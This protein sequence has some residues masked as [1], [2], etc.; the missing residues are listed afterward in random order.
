LDDSALDDSAFADSAFADSAFAD[1]AFTDS[2][3]ADSAFA[4][5]IQI[6]TDESYTHPTEVLTGSEAFCRKFGKEKK[7]VPESGCSPK[8]T[9]HL[10]LKLWQN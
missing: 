4:N 6:K 9:G 1:S 7:I 10:P 2:A 3:F 5:C 8:K